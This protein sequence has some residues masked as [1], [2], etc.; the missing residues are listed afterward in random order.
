M[1]KKLTK[2]QAYNTLLV[3]LNAYYMQNKSDNVCDFITHAFFWFDKKPADP[4]AWQEWKKALN[5]IARQDISLR[6]NSLTQLQ[7]LNAVTKFFQIYCDLYTS[8]PTDMLHV[9][10]IFNDLQKNKN[11][12][13][14]W[15]QWQ[16]AIHEVLTKKDPR[17]YIQS[18]KNINN[19]NL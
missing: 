8:I 17:F 11:K 15:L 4:V 19:E 5:F 2:L 16:E 13:R 14:M 18:A 3:F 9:L 7:T 10:H 12:S 6:N 1:Q